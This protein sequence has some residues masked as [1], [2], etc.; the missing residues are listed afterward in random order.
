LVCNKI[1]SYEKITTTEEK[2]YLNFLIE[3][4]IIPENIDKLTNN[5]KDNLAELKEFLKYVKYNGKKL[6]EMIQL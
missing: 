6:D 1:L 5:T 2:Q 4:K 3:A